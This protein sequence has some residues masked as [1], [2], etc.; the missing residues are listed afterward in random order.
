METR[1]IVLIT[2]VNKKERLKPA[3]AVADILKKWGIISVFAVINDPAIVKQIEKKGY[4]TVIVKKFAGTKGFMGKLLGSLQRKNLAKEAAK[5]LS[6]KH[7][8]AVLS[9]GG[10]SSFPF[11]DAAVKM[12]LKIF[13]LEVNSVISESNMEFLSHAKKIYLPFAEMGS[14]LD[15][16]KVVASGV[17]VDKDVLIAEGRN[18]PTDKKLLV[19]FSCKKDSN[20]INELVRGLFRKYPEMKKEFFVLQETG[21]KDVASVQRFYEEIGVEA[22]CYMHYENRGKYYKTADLIICRP[23]ADVFSELLAMRKTGI[24]LPLPPKYDEHQKSNAVMMNRLGL[25]YLVEDTGSTPMRIK[26]L[27]SSLNA[28][29]T[30][31]AKVK[32]NIDRLEYEK[33]ATRVASDIEKVLS[34]KN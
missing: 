34:G 11:L 20:S 17:P 19:I 10:V 30:S 23:T 29:F 33:S 7:V 2:G 5:V 1:F 22:L 4:D 15:R 24:L 32:Q 9:I 8:Q 13:L 28:F 31:N 6:T 16:S 3:I 18:I 27:Y 25:G 26:K 21:E 14:G 12:N